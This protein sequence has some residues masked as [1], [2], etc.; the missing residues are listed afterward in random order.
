MNE[1]NPA[2]GRF[3]NPVLGICL[4]KGVV[5]R[6]DVGFPVASKVFW[7]TVTIRID[8]CTSHLVTSEPHLT[9]DHDL[10]FQKLHPIV[11]SRFA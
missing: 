4:D 7:Y 8:M 11:G 3:K 1:A 5:W 6:H 2:V 9:H 10:L